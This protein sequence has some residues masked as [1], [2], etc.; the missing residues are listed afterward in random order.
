MAVKVHYDG[1]LC[2]WCTENRIQS[3]VA[4]NETETA[5]HLQA[6]NDRLSAQIAT[7]TTENHKLKNT[8]HILARMLSS[9][10]DTD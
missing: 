8:C 5:N 9:A 1:C 2:Y 4:A 3:S 6:E 7:L 10:Y